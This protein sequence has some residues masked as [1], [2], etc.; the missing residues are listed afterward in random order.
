MV[1]KQRKRNLN[2]IL[3]L[4][5]TGVNDDSDGETFLFIFESIISKSLSKFSFILLSDTFIS[6]G[7]VF[8][9]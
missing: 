3:G 6:P 5:M 9:V 1:I 7:L 8:F 2:Q 4:L